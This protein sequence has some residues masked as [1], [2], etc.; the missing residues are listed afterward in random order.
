MPP[1]GHFPHRLSSA[2]STREREKGFG[3]NKKK[4]G[5]YYACDV[6]KIRIKGKIMYVLWVGSGSALPQGRTSKV[7]HSAY[8]YIHTYILLYII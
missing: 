3:H 4:I 7:G 6:K 1:I 8:T 5:V 2:I